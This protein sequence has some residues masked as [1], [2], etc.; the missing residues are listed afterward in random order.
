[1]SE[2]DNV[3][4][5]PIKDKKITDYFAGSM[6]VSNVHQETLVEPSEWDPVI[7]RKQ[8]GLIAKEKEVLNLRKQFA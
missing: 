4:I 5:K 6:R 3:T 1:M 8:E 2:Q 7:R